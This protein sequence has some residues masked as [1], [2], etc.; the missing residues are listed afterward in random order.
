MAYD[1]SSYVNTET[2]SYVEKIM[3]RTEFL[4]ILILNYVDLIKK[5]HGL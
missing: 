5:E 3:R 2:Y 1:G 4:F